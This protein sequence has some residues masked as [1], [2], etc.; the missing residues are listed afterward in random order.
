L[1]AIENPKFHEKSSKALPLKCV[2]SHHWKDINENF[3]YVKYRMID[4]IEIIE[5]IS[6]FFVGKYSNLS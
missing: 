2:Q 5:K 6:N 1:N 3:F 4:F